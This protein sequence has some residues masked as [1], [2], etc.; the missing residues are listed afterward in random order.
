MFSPEGIDK[1]P[2]DAIADPTSRS[3]PVKLWAVFVL[4]AGA[5]GV[6]L[7]TMGR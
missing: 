6:L 1:T 3:G 4:L 2:E 5:I 7:W